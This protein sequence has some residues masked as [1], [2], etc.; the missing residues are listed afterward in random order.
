VA[1]PGRPP[2]P[3]AAD[4][5]PAG[6][7]LGAELRRR[8]LELGLTL[9]ELGARAGY[10]PQHVSCLELALAGATPT[11]ISALDAALSAR[12]ALLELLSPA[13]AERLVAADARATRRRYDEDVEPTNRRALLGG[14]AGAALGAAALGPVP[15]AAREVDPELPAH[16]S[17]LLR[18]L[19][20][21]DDLFGPRDVLDTVRRELRLIAEHRAAARGELRIEL[22]RVEARWSDLAAWLSEDSGD[23]RARDT[24][25]ERSRQLA[26]EAEYADMIAFAR[27]RH[28]R[29]IEWAGNNAPR[30]VACAEDALRTRRASAQTR[31]WCARQ[32]ALGHALAGDAAA[33][34]G[35][36][37]DA[38]GWLEDDD[39]PAPPW[40]GEFRVTHTGT[41][42]AEACCWLAMA[43]AKAIGLYEAALRD[44]PSDEARDGGL[45]QAR[46]ALACAKAG[47]LDRAQAEGRKALAI[48]RKTRS[49]TTTRE[50]RRLGAVL[51]AA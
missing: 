35:R 42:A 14:A 31:A 6:A 13:V 51:T 29:A 28:A 10:S 5:P 12:G 43:P 36:M 7:R 2:K 34:E 16:W 17:N 32:A 4:A 27:A 39:S 37:H 1:G 15:A 25:I 21:H 47:E 23:L 40:A 45:Y 33:C 48:A 9:A 38:Y 3:L 50:L 46:L 26:Q 24:W 30:A 41:L 11:C 44:W 49:A 22:M 19:G 8:R 20:R 18:L